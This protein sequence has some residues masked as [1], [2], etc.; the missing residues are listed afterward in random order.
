MKK[1]IAYV[2][3]FA[4]LLSVLAAFIG[5]GETGDGTETT[6]S[7][8]TAESNVESTTVEVDHRFD[9]V[10]YDGREFRIYVNS[11]TDACI[12]IAPTNFFEGAGVTTGDKVND[13]VVERNMQVEELIDVTLVHTY[14]NLGFME[15]MTDI[16]TYTASGTD[17][18]DLVM[19]YLLPFG[20]LVV[21]G[22]FCNVQDEGVFDFDRPYWY[23][24]CM[25]D[26]RLVDDYQYL[27]AGDYF[28]NVLRQVHISLLNKN[29]YMDYY[30]R[31]ADELYDMVL[32]YEWTLDKMN[33]IIADK[34]VDLNGNGVRDNGDRFGYINRD[35]WGY[36]EPFVTCSN[37]PFIA[38]DEDGVPSITLR[39][40]ER[41]GQI[42]DKMT[43]LYHNESTYLKFDTETDLY[44]AFSRDESLMVGYQFL[45]SL[46]ND[47]FRQMESDVA[48]LPYPMLNASDKKY[49]SAFQESAR[50][51]AIPTTST[52]MDFIS[53]VIEV[54]N[55][56]SASILIPQYYHEGLKV[57]LVDDEKAAAM[58]DIIHDNVGNSFI[59]G[60]NYTL[61]NEVFNIFFEAAKSK[62]TFDVVYKGY[63]KALPRALN[64]ALENFRK[65]NDVD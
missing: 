29:L 54:L 42:A 35:S 17:E 41:S 7:T 8:V 33:E 3:L 47:V 26:L 4:I 28:I 46:E 63:E 57:R 16:R 5:C 23:K 48:V 58:I 43:Q 1:L 49:T 65:N 12:S 14:C 34:Y 44:M 37:P 59:V 39:E 6:H 45:G 53:T 9:N 38:R 62:R 10:D 55:R 2:S 36:F 18:V 64:K 20:T 52:D 50:M 19:G 24:E 15:T 21:E 56:E 40:G 31:S 51:G 32:N 11:N 60:Y 27:L 25:E 61:G 13:A 30:H 22:H